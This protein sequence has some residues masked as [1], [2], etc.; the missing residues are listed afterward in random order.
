M[1]CTEVAVTAPLLAAAPK[2]DTHAPTATSDAPAASVC[3]MT[4]D[5]EVVI[6]SF[7]AFGCTGFLALVDLVEEDKVPGVICRPVIEI[8]VPLTA[9]TLP[10]AREKLP[11]GKNRRGAPAADPLR[12]V[13][14]GPPPAPNPPK[15]P[16]PGPPPT[17]VTLEPEAPI[18][19]PVHVPVAGAALMVMLVAAMVVFDFLAGVPLTVMQAPAARAPRVSVTVLVNVVEVVHE[20]VV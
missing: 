4:V 18:P 17:R 5:F 9:V 14:P 15:P 13:L 11:P 3:V 10:L 8:V 7:L 19:G 12:K 20:T 16:P 2:A 1:M 6:L